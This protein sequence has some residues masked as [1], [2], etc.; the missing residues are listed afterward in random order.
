MPELLLELFSEE[1][2]ARFQRSAAQTLKK[3]VTNALVDNGLSYE[4]AAAFATPRRLTLT[5][6]GLPA[7]SPD[8]RQ[9]RKGPRVGA[10]PKAVEGFLRGAG[11][12]SIEDAQV[13]T[14]PK[15]GDFY[16]AVIEKPG[17]R[18][19]D[20]LARILP[21]I[22]AKFPWAKPMRW[23]TGRLNWVRPLRAITATFGSDNEEPEVVAFDAEGLAAGQTTFGHRFMAPDAIKVR[24]FDDYRRAL[25]KAKVVLDID[26]RKDIIYGEADNLAF[27]QGLSVITND[28]L[29]EEVAGLVEWPV[30]MMGTFDQEFL[31]LPQEAVVAAIRVHQKCFCLRDAKTGQ[32]ANRF[33]LTANTEATDGGKEIVAGNEKVIRARLSDAKF[34]YETDLKAKLEDSVER[35][36]DSVFHAKLGSQFER[37]ERLVAL[38]A[39]IA[40]YVGADPKS[41]ARAALLA[42]ADLVTGM[43]GEFPELQ[44]LIG[45]YYA[46]AQGETADVAEAIEMH[47]K[48]L[49]PSDQVPSDP[50][51]IAVA[52]ADKIDLL[53]GFWAIDEK[54]TGSRDPFALRRAALGVIRIA[55]ENDLPINPRY[56]LE[57]HI[58]RITGIDESPENANRIDNLCWFLE[59]R[60]EVIFRDKDVQHDLFEA[61][62]E[63]AS[64]AEGYSIQT[65]AARIGALRGLLDTDTGQS[66]LHSYKRAVNI[67]PE[68]F[69]REDRELNYMVDDS[70]FLT[71]EERLFHDAL[72]QVA[73]PVAE[74]VKALDFERAMEELSNLRGPVDAFFEAVLV[75]DE[76]PKV[77]TNRLNLLARLR[78]TMHLVADFSKLAG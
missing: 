64:L 59:G 63:K 62:L 6:T 47:Y 29:L 18:S 32:L 72:N 2:P 51:S 76:D 67:L 58:S 23:G 48:P 25:E 21:E 60:L 10:P 55:L 39:E 17:V 13:S 20:I 30:P 49:G 57:K 27:A 45:R 71:S 14:D 36:R 78:D 22:I 41:A 56:I 5:A 75:N 42:K 7:R 74:A 1:I 52:L 54:P 70:L 65:I 73:A 50:V 12:A 43:V 3:M 34:F 15:K 68:A 35:L 61:V 46:I 31:A 44:G 38:A 26:R 66:L 53:T 8:T 77:R 16:L 69:S 40:P 24:R 19:V 37:V 9:E 11:L 28:G 4:S 33:I